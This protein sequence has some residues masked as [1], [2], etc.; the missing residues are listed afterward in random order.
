MTGPKLTGAAS[1]PHLYG[2]SWRKAR[3]VFLTEHPLCSMCEDEGK[4]SAAHEVDHIQKH[5]GDP[6][7]FWDVKNWQAL[8]SFHH[9]SV[10]AELERSG[11]IRGTK[12]NGYPMDPNHPWNQ[13]V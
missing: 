6:V 12:I 10:K 3:R 13:G 5:N 9:R 7:L 8:C 4:T 2:R 1:F 11:K